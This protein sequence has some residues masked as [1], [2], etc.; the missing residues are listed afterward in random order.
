MTW[1]ET[2]AIVL[3]P[4]VA[5]E[6]QKIVFNTEGL[7]DFVF[8]I[9]FYGLF[10][11]IF[12]FYYATLVEGQIVKQQSENVVNSISQSIKA[13]APEAFQA[14]ANSLTVE[15]LNSDDKDTC[16]KNRKVRR[17]SFIVFGSIFA[18]TL[19]FA[20]SFIF[21]YYITKSKFGLSGMQFAEV[22][23]INVIIILLIAVSEYSYLTFF[24]R[25]FR[26]LDPNFVQYTLL[27][28]IE[29]KLQNS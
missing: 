7:V 14:F 9:G 1:Q 8:H 16:K 11:T 20:A 13:A 24:A 28:S 12:F 5:L 4:F 2:V 15:K 3:K 19:L 29:K 6:N 22:I 18:F 26:T 25:N 23:Y 10:L 21:S 27:D 17:Q